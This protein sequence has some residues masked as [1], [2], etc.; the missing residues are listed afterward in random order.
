M[1]RNL[2]AI[3]FALL[4]CTQS[5]I[6]QS[7]YLTR[8]KEAAVLIPDKAAQADSVLSVVLE[9]I[10]TQQPYND[11]LFVLTYF[12]LGTNN[13]YQGKLNLAL[14]FLDNRFTTIKEIFFP[15]RL[16]LVWVTKPS[17]LKNST[18]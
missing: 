5:A 10:S 4:F 16:C 2:H 14:D 7:D 6:G 15:E 9:E 11:S 13:L 8:I 1:T 18:G 12:L 17:Y 3:I